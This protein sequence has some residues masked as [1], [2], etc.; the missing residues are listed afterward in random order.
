MKVQSSSSSADEESLKHLH[1]CSN[2]KVMLFLFKTVRIK[3]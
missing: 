3:V 2:I 1:M